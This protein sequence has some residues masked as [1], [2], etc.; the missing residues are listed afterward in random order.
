MK[1]LQSRAVWGALLV[2]AG[3]L[4]LAESLKLIALGS[5]WGILFLVAG[6]IFLA[7][8][9]TD[10][11]SWW[12][13]IP[14][15]T[16][17]GLGGL[18]TVSEL[19]PGLAG[20]LA[21]GLFLG[22]IGLGFLL[23]YLITRGLQWWALI[24]GGILLTLGIAIGLEPII[25]GEAFVAVFFLGMALSFL[26]VYLLPSR[27]GKM[28]WAIIPAIVLGVIGIVFLSIA[29]E[30]AGLIWAVALIAGGVYLVLR[31]LRRG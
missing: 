9:L 23:V 12:A 25:G 21:P 24:P 10:R 15:M 29:V 22:C 3:L 6:A 20:S 13:A 5:I 26:L 7:V 18:I 17:V 1:T 19:A 14:G 31:G 11:S 28:G 4:L 16:L 27:Y 30:V 8:L 2:I